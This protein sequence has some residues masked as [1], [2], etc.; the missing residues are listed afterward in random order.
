MY[1]YIYK[2]TFIYIYVLICRI[3]AIFWKQMKS[4]E[5]T[6]KCSFLM[7]RSYKIL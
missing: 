4:E 1:L 6:A 5:P 7:V 3:S 2:C